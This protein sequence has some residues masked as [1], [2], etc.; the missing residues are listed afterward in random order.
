MFIIPKF[1]FDILE[2]SN[3]FLKLLKFNKKTTNKKNLKIKL[4]KRK[5]IPEFYSIS[6]SLPLIKNSSKRIRKKNL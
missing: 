4:Q 5:N 6:F 3:E 2:V 1:F